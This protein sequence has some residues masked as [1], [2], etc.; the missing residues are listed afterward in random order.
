MEELPEGTF[1]PVTFLRIS[2]YNS[3][4]RT[5][6]PS[7]V[8]SSKDRLEDVIIQWSQLEGFPF[9]ILPDLTQLLVLD[10]TGNSLTSVPSLQSFSLQ[11]L[12]LRS[13]NIANIEGNWSTPGLKYLY[14]GEYHV[15][16]TAICVIP[17]SQAI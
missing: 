9:E 14:L 2:I 6:H 10:L 15:F 11:E 17:V 7:V 1:G 3:E 16:R 13:N 8:L 12:Y 5:L 4:I